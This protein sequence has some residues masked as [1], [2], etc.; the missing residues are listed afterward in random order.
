MPDDKQPVRTSGRGPAPTGSGT[1][2]VRALDGFRG[3]AIGGVV[4]VHLLGVSG[5]LAATAGTQPGVALWAIFSNSIDAFFIISGFVLFLPAVRS[6]GDLGSRARFWIARAARLFPAYWLVLAIGILLLIF[7]VGWAGSV[8]PSATDIA[9][10]LAVLQQPMALLDGDFRIGFGTNPP[11]WLL[12]IVVAFYAILPFI[13]GRYFRHPLLGLAAAAAL[14]IGWKLTVDWAPWIFESISSRPPRTMA[15]LAVDQFPGWAFSFGLGMTSAWAY[16]RLTA[17]VAPGRLGRYATRSL[18]LTVPLYALAS[19]LYARVALTVGGNIGPVARQDTVAATLQTALRG[20]IILAVICGPLWVRR[21]FA[22][23]ITDRLA[24]LS[25]GVYLIH[26][27]LVIYLYQLTGL[28]RDGTFLAF[29]IWVAAVVP[30]SL[31]FAA[32][33]RRWLELPVQAWMR[34]RMDASPRLRRQVP[35]DAPARP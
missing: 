23:P 12:S 25:Y 32:A 27:L 18:L 15:G 5:V 28:P 2:R 31:L 13:A 34:R 14:T 7:G 11:V 35:A 10:H 8:M 16:E 26:W 9:A 6:G 24:E 1:R 4:A 20:A 29:L 21:P 22:N 30:A 19:Y 33:S 3:Y 17:R